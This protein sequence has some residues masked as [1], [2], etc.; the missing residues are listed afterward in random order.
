[1]NDIDKDLMDA[2][3]ETVH[4]I[5]KLDQ[6]KP[7][8]VM[9][10][11]VDHES[12]L[13]NVVE[14]S[15]TRLS[16]SFNLDTPMTDIN[17][18]INYIDKVTVQDKRAFDL[19]ASKVVTEVDSRARFKA[20]L[21]SSILLSKLADMVAKLDQF[22]YNADPM[23]YLMLIERFLL[24]MEKSEKLV[25]VYK[26]PTVDESLRNLSESKNEDKHEDKLTQADYADL[27]KITLEKI[28]NEQGKS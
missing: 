15:L 6:F 4:E 5:A 17:D 7:E 13:D 21:S 24:F 20:T 26:D 23:S 9:T 18:V 12:Q 10:E 27:V 1:M 16:K 19:L 3:Y 28:R 25:S 2:D 22:D 11:S 14:D 8:P